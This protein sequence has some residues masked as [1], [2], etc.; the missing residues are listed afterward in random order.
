MESDLALYRTAAQNLYAPF[1]PEDGVSVKEIEMAEKSFGFRLPKILR[2]FYLLAGNR[3]AIN[4]SHNRL[5]SV[6]YLEIE[7]NKL[8]F[9]QENQAAFC[10]AVDLS[11]IEKD[12]PPVWV[13]QSVAGR[14]ALE[15]HFDSE[16]LSYFLL[17]ML[18]WQSVMGGLAFTGLA[19]KIEESAVQKVKDNFALL[20]E[21]KYNTVFQ[22]FIAKGKILCL[23]AS[24]KGT[25][26]YAG[27]S[28]EQ[29]FREIE[30]LLQIKWDYC[31]L[32]D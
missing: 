11:D 15:W 29:N 12:D 19:D 4:A 8:I 2:E 27:A 3:K 10:W 5:L 25:D 6:E 16:H 18:C 23:A 28:D 1:T 24:Q 31:Y 9:Y 32:D 22:A 14:D 30:D 26:F 21:G 17:M 20:D 13:G 7:D